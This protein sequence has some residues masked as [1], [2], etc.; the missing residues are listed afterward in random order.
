MRERV[1]A[2]TVVSTR[3]EVGNTVRCL[4]AGQTP[5]QCTGQT[6]NWPDTPPRA[7][8]IL[9]KGT[10]AQKERWALD[11]LTLGVLPLLG[12]EHAERFRSPLDSG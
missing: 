1:A 5:D 11:L 4:Y 6:Q 7:S 8:S 9:Y 10:T 2:T 3:V 12:S